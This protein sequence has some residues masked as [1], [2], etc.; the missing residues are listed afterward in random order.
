[1]QPASPL[2]WSHPV[3]AAIALVLAFFVFRQGMQQRAQRLRRIPA[4]AGTWQRHLALGPW[5][6][7]LLVASALGGVGSAVFLRA[8]KPLDTFH[9]WL[10]VACAA[11]FVA[12]WVMGRQLAA[13]KKSLAQAHGVIGLLAMFAAGLTGVLG[14]SLLP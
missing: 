12:Q 9:G 7:G 4:P 8:W 14:I 6:V 13:G 5:S 2:S 3:M 11:A 10:G 1:M